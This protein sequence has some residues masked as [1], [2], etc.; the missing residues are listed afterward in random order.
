M[1]HLI[2]FLALVS[3]LSYGVTGNSVWR[4]PSGGSL[5]AWG[6]VN[7]ADGINAITGALP[8]KANLP[9]VGMQ[10]SASSGNFSTSSTPYV[11]VTNLTVTLTT[12]GRPVMVGLM[13]DGTANTIFGVGCNGATGCDGS[14][15]VNRDGSVIAESVVRTLGPTQLIVPPGGLNAMDPV[16]AGTH[17]YK[18]QAKNITVGGS[19]QAVVIFTTLWAYEL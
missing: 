19:T 11:D 15:A 2:L 8:S 12:T 5:G 14:F 13:G 16:T 4:I 10:L 18:I 9:A 3:N 1:R 7:L 17:T 6:P